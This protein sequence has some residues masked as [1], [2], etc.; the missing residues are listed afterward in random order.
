[1]TELLYMNSI[2]GN[3]IRE[4]NATVTKEK[5]DY[6]C[7]DQTAFYPLGGGQPSDVGFLQW[8]DK[9]TEVKEVIKKAIL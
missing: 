4:F 1:M 3:Y 6:V 5:K 7:L 9:K 8:D 2:E